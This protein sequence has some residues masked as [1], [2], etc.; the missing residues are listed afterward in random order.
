M[1]KSATRRSRSREFLAYWW[2]CTQDSVRGLSQ[3]ANDWQWLFGIPAVSGVAGYLTAR[4]GRTAIT[5]GHPILDGVLAAFGAFVV[6]W[7]MAFFVRLFNA[8]VAKDRKQRGEIARL[9][10]LAGEVRSTSFD[11]K[12]CAVHEKDADRL[13]YLSG[14]EQLFRIAITNLEIDKSLETYVLLE[15]LPAGAWH[16]ASRQTPSA[17]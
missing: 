2:Q 4:Q 9:K 6:T 15:G 7:L 13:E 12:V 10:E 11:V 17:R 8:P 3:F 1:P 5:T 16:I 14:D